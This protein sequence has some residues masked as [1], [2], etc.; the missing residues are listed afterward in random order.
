MLSHTGEMIVCTEVESLC[1]HCL[2]SAASAVLV[3][4]R[5]RTTATSPVPR[6][7]P[8][9]STRPRFA[10]DRI[11][12]KL[13]EDALLLA[14]LPTGLYAEA[15]AFNINEL[16]QLFRVNGGDKI[17]RAH[18]KVNDTAWERSTGFHRW[19]LITLEGKTSVEQAIKSFKANRYIEE[20]IPEY[21]AYTT[22]IP[23]DPYYANNW[24]H[25]NTAQLPVY[26]GGSHSGAGV[27][28]VGFDAHMQLA[29]DQSQGYGDIYTIIA[30][31]DTGVDTSHPDLRLVAGYDYGDNDANPM[32]NSADPGHGTACSGVAAG[33]ANNGLG[34]TGVAGGC[35]VMPLKIAS[36][37]G[38]LYFTAIENALTHC[39]DNN[40]DVASM[41]FGAE[42]GMG[43]G[44]SS[45]TDSALEYAYSHGVTL[46]AA[47]A[48]SNAAVIA[49][50]SNHNKVISVGASSPT[51]QRKS[52]SS[53]DG[54]NWWGSNYGTATQD[55][56]NAVDI[57]A[58]TILPATDITGTGN[59]YNTSSDYYMW[60][61]GTS[62][63][64]P[65]AA[66]VAALLISKD[67]TLTPAAV[68]QAL[69]STCTDMTIDGG[70]GWDRYTGYGMVNANAA[71]SS[72]VP[73]MP[74][75]NITA[76]SSGETIDLNS[77]VTI[78]V[79]ATDTDGIINN[80]KFYI[81]DVL[82]S[83][84]TTSPYSWNWNTTGYSAGSHSIKA[85]ATD[86]SANTSTSVVTI[87][88]IPP[89][90]E[91][92][93]TAD[94]SAYP[95]VN[96]SAIPWT[97]QSTDSYSG[98]YA[99]RSGQIGDGT[100]T[101][102]SLSLN[103]VD[104]GSIS[105]YQRVSSESEWDYLRFY[106]DD[107]LQGEWSG[108]VNWTP[109]S[110]PVSLGFHTFKWEYSKDSS[111]SSGSDCAWLDHLVLPIFNDF[112]PPRNLSGSAGSGTISLGWNA[113]DAN[114]PSSYNIYRDGSLL[115]NV[116]G[117]SHTDNTVQNG[118][119][120][121]YY[122]TSLYT[123][124]SG[125]SI[126][127]NSITLTPG[128]VSNDYTI[129]TGTSA[130]GSTVAC[131]INIYYKSRH[132][133]SI[134]TAAE[135]IAAG[136]TGPVDITRIG[137]YIDSVPNEALPNFIVRMKHTSAADVT[138]WQS[139]EGMTT[140]YT[141]GSYM[142]VAGDFHMLELSSPFT[143]DGVSNLLV[144]TAFSQVS[145]W[146]QSGSV[147]YSS[148][149]NGYR[150]T[151]SDSADQT[152]VFSAGYT[153]ISRPNIR[154]TTAFLPPL[155]AIEVTPE[156]MLF[157]TVMINTS[158]A[159]SF[160]IS[161]PGTATLTGNISTPIAYTV[162]SSRDAGALLSAAGSKKQ[163]GRNSL[164][165]SIPAGESSTFNLSFTPTAVQAYN[166]TIT[167]THNVGGANRTIILSGQG[168]KPG[169]NL[170][171][172]SF[173]ANLVPNDS[174]AQVLT[175]SNSGNMDLAYSMSISGSV[176]WLSFAGSSTGSISAG[177]A[178]HNLT[179][180]YDATGL[181]AGIYSA[182][183][184]GSSND[185]NNTSVTVDI[186]LNVLAPLITV[187]PGSIDFGMVPV[188]QSH[189]ESFTISNPGTATLTGQIVT[190]LFLAVSAARGS[191]LRTA[192]FTKS[193][194]AIGDRNTIS[195]EI[196]PGESE[197][198]SASFS[199]T[200]VTEY[201]S[202]IL[203]MHN[204]DVP[205]QEIEFYGIGAQAILQW[206]PP[207]IEVDLPFSG[208]TMISLDLDNMGNIPLTFTANRAS[209]SYPFMING[210]SSLSGSILPWSSFM[211][212]LHFSA[213]PT[214]EDTYIAAIDI[215]SNDPDHDFVRI[216]ITIN[217][218]NPNH[219]PVLNL[220]PEMNVPYNGSKA[221]NFL[222][223]AADQDDDDLYVVSVI[224]G[225]HITLVGNRLTPDLNWYGEEEMQVTISDGE[226]E[227]T[228]QMMIIVNAPP[229]LDI[230]DEFS[231][232]RNDSLFVNFRDYII[233]PEM[234]DYNISFTGN[235]AISIH[236]LGTRASFS[237]PN[238][239]AG[240]ESITISVNDVWNTVQDSFTINVINHAPVLS[241]PDG[242]SLDQNGS[243]TVDFTPYI[244]D[245]DGDA[246]DLSYSENGNV[247][248]N[249]DGYSVTFSPALDWFGTQTINFSLS[250]GYLQS[251]DTVSITVEQVIDHLDSPVVTIQGNSNGIMIHWPA[252]EYATQYQVFRSADPYGGYE[253]IA[254]TTNPMYYDNLPPDKA[255]YHV[256]AV[257]TPYSK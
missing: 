144:D 208:S 228:D 137:F 7:Q 94:F 179:L 211:L 149:A 151:Q 246:L 176:P 47:T 123:S 217:V 236:Q 175:V 190:P 87:T 14:N 186:A 167:I 154:F 98:T 40:V 56:Q 38:S 124:G 10:T 6:A 49:Y 249:I 65:Y 29:W 33:R 69:V 60:F 20:A 15:S 90:N 221:V 99:A 127:S 116:T 199:P 36:S 24:G 177:G 143:W 102:L 34:V 192:Q 83:T 200:D 152:N 110:Y 77:S 205:Q 219:P 133:Q 188:G 37:D 159:H 119:S 108:E 247:M 19:F 67:N 117:T 185:P 78:N 113:P 168:G 204:A 222:A 220:P 82:K 122:V 242:Y 74:S 79:A 21:I 182:S 62:C 32:D 42:E 235:S 163:E 130:T 155:P 147:R 12:I 232:N 71:L 201:H 164:E 104:P 171:A 103:V 129:G 189:S 52:T 23:N 59:G 225:P 125:E 239:F 73:G 76:P 84:D 18:R 231:F 256:K 162:S 80:V 214:G 240:S 146:S 237:A 44:D 57:M 91:G 86:N 229:T 243:L 215:H 210:S 160:Q 180:A 153:H 115:T 213:P 195:F 92:F 233:D 58:P 66:G 112:F 206:N 50:P 88:L 234:D 31:I 241:V 245:P 9:S 118:V 61:N 251:S 48:N 101:V 253:L 165:F 173:T 11:K 170:S 132:G 183:I 111:A 148:I 27:G 202:A 97:V 70:T 141:S 35:S 135:L 1:S 55:D 46:L 193:R 128:M 13:S 93:E 161:N 255:F 250:D 257:Y 191:A 194:E 8:P 2:F 184:I 100:N 198:F 45:S 54:E 5:D 95:W 230:P 254:T 121:T 227:D 28:T 139:A 72:L 68:R 178:A 131:P 30:I 81:D 75:C 89:A 209:G 138:D 158:S 238:G 63:A 136:I 140:V 174:E 39:G 64:T 207:S 85:I 145:Q 252:V 106:L 134:Y 105:F 203:I 26:S 244:S 226:F 223:Y 25:N 197:D 156:S 3:L 4:K 172:T 53:S 150:Y 248:V 166:G 107:E 109:Q 51:G 22:A 114:T 157:G 43:E 96:S 181:S 142:P 218:F 224:T 169:L 187:S 196:P 126:P 17:I 216:P 16:D 120:Y 41:S 212:Q